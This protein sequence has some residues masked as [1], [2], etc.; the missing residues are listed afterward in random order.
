MVRTIL[1]SDEFAAAIG[2]K[3]KRPF[4]FLV[5]AL[6]ALSADM[7][8][9]TSGGSQPG[10]G[11]R[12]NPVFQYLLALGQVPFMWSTP[13]GYPDKA[14]SWL[15][16][17][18]LLHRW[19][20]GLALAAG[21]KGVSINS[22]ALVGPIQSNNELVDRVAEVLLG[23]VMVDPQRAILIDY[24]RS[25]PDN[26]RLPGLLALMVGSSQFQVR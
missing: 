16:T 13:D 9:D 12:R 1:T 8:L 15:S 17:N 14:V 23:A 2:Q 10:A 4:E 18:G 24:A 3:Y 22:K 6:R 11:L 20:F 26:L 25:V 5:S 21:V 7:S 19:N